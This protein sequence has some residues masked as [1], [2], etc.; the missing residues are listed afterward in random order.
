MCR[1][2]KSRLEACG[3][4][5]PGANAWQKRH[6]ASQLDRMWYNPG[7]TGLKRV[8]AGDAPARSALRCDFNRRLIYRRANM[9]KNFAPDLFLID[10]LYCIMWV[11]ACHRVHI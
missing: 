7:I 3:Q 11:I 5:S 1:R 9:Y 4:A 8:P 10:F 2:L 6:V